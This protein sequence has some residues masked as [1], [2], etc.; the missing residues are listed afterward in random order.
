MTT[1]GADFADAE[2]ADDAGDVAAAAVARD[3]TRGA[4]IPAG[5]KEVE[6]E[7]EEEAPLAPPAGCHDAHVVPPSPLVLSA[8]RRLLSAD[9]PP[10]VCLLY[11][12]PPVCLLFAS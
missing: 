8:L 3:L 9:A 7:E 2:L 5:G 6:E 11:A 1:V 12:S 4:T 10:P